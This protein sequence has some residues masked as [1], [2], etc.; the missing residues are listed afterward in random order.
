MDASAISPPP[1]LID[2][3]NAWKRFVCIGHVTP[4]ADCLGAIFS[5]ARV[6]SA[7]GKRRISVA[8]PE[9][10]L[11]QRL[12]FMVELA[13]I[14]VATA[15]DFDA[16]DG[17]F[18]ADTAKKPRCN[19]PSFIGDDWAA[20]KPILNVDHHVSNTRFGEI[21]WVVDGAASSCELIH[22]I[23]KQAGIEI[24]ATTAFLLYAGIFTD[25]VGFSL[26]STTGF[27]LRTA[28]ELVDRGA[29]VRMLGERISRSQ[30][31]NEFR[32]LRTIY[33]NTHLTDNNRIAYSTASFE[34]ITGAGCGPADI[35]EQVAVPRS[36]QG[37]K[38]A[39][40]FSEG[41]KGKTRMNFRGEQGIN[42]L[43]LARQFN[44]GGHKEAAGAILDCGIEEAVA[45]VLPAAKEA[46]N[47][48]EA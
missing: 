24:D 19:I 32:L 27:A 35:D 43:E 31:V 39:L 7:G 26:P 2:G 30:T 9:G 17:F 41:N 42:V 6:W 10:S 8:L 28:A 29:D 25:T 34:E 46:I 36:V 23:I 21:N 37:I 38:I 3:L 48:Q 13:G 5:I 18:V 1:E 11:S 16:A 47:R 4:D 12:A 22:A 40:L 15:E 20:G 14:D 44:G 45:R 33:E